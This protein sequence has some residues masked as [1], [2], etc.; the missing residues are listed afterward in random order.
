MVADL[1]RPGLVLGRT[2]AEVQELLGPPSG[3]RAGADEWIIG[4]WSGFGMDADGMIVVYDDDD[5]AVR[6]FTSQH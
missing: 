5:V 1:T 3:D 6:I 4:M 2:R